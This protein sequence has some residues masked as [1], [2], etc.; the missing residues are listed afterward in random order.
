MLLS[1]VILEGQGKN[2]NLLWKMSMCIFSMHKKTL[3][4][5]MNESMAFERKRTG[6]DF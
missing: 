6:F 1:A 3:P 2:E 4:G 5:A